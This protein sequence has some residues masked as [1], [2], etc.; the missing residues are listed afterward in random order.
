MRAHYLQHVSFEGLG[1]IESWLQNKEYEIT[2]TAFFIDTNFPEAHAIDFL[3]IMGGPM[4][5]NDEALFPWLCAEKE[6]IR[7]VIKL[8]KPV[9]GICL[10]AQLIASA[11]G[12]KIYQNPLKEIGWFPIEGVNTDENDVFVFPDLLE[13]FH[14]H[15]ETFDLPPNAIHLARST[16]CNNQA[17]QLGTTVMGLQF[18]LEMT[19]DSVQ[20]IISHSHDELITSV[21]IQSEEEMLSASSQRYAENT[22]LMYDILNFLTQQG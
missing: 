9:L 16:G 19:P 5:V 7:E 21:Y 13:V 20:E 18:H 2:R 10:G 17:F 4:S 12:A 3:I 6:F 14:W 8:E 11:M 22:K 1:N 15:G